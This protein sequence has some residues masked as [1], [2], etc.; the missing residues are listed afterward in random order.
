LRSRRIPDQLLAKRVLAGAGEA[1]YRARP[2]SDAG[3]RSGR[4]RGPPRPFAHARTRAASGNPGLGRG[5][6]LDALAGI[7]LVVAAYCGTANLCSLRKT[8]VSVFGSSPWRRYAPFG[9]DNALPTR[10]EPCTPVQFSTIEVNGRM[11]VSHRTLPG[12]GAYAKRGVPS[13]SGMTQ[14]FRRVE[15]LPPRAAAQA[16]LAATRLSL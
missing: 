10:Y 14:A 3:R 8:I 2:V 5:D 15:A 9:A 1:P 13:P 4:T 12:G 6:F 7:D 11:G 16:D